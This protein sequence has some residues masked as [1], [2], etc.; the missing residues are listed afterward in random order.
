MSPCALWAMGG[1]ASV[2]TCSGRRK[3]LLLGRQVPGKPGPTPT[4]SSAAPVPAATSES[5]VTGA[6][7]EGWRA[8]LCAGVC[9]ASAGPRCSLGRKYV[10]EGPGAQQGPPAAASSQQLCCP[11]FVDPCRHKSSL[12]AAR[13][14]CLQSPALLLGK[15]GSSASEC[16]KEGVQTRCMRAVAAPPQS[17]QQAV[18]D[19]SAR[20]GAQVRPKDAHSEKKWQTLF[21]VKTSAS[22]WG[23]W[24]RYR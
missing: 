18:G 21:L 22:A 19:S 23:R 7:P 3:V 24:G 20:S 14:G 9:P 17:H 6:A 8:G 16:L 13:P 1:P 11:S 10:G 2:T 12:P 5:Q 4:N 15:P